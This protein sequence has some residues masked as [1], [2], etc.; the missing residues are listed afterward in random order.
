[1]RTTARATEPRGA[2]GSVED[3]ETALTGAPLRTTRDS[4]RAYIALTKP[5]IIELLLVTTVPA[6]VLATRWV[7]G[8]DWGDWGWRVAWTLI[9]GTLEIESTPG[10]GTTI[11]ARVPFSFPEEGVGEG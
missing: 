2:G 1:M 6:M 4:V 10:Q 11:F 5:R 3:P 9:G 7:P 8:I